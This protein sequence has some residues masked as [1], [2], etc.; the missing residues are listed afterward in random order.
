MTIRFIQVGIGG[1][2]SGWLRT[3][4]ESN[5][6][7]ELVAYVDSKSEALQ[8]AQTIHTLP[9]ERCFTR[10]EDALDTVEADAVLIVKHFL[11]HVPLSLHA[12][13]YAKHVL[14]EKPFAQK[15]LDALHVVYTAGQQSC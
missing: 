6:G 14:M 3:L 8:H 1:W 9:A 15:L 5:L 11:T 4:I 13:K 12:L 7:V 2:G 10:L